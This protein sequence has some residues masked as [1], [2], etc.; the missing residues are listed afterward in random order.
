MRKLSVELG[1]RSYPIFVGSGTLSTLASTLA[2]YINQ[3]VFIITNDVVAPLYLDKVRNQLADHQIAVFQMADGEQAKTLDTWAAA[4]DALLE[5]GFSRDCTVLALGGGVVG[6]LAGFV[7]ASFQ[8][9]V[10]FI[11]IPTTLLSQV[12]SSVGGK[13]AVNHPR[14]KNLVGAFHQPK[15]VLID[16]E[17]LSTLPQRELS[18]GL[19]EVIK[20]G[21]MADAEFFNWLENNISALMA[22]DSQALIHAITRSCECKAEVV[23]LDELE[24]GQRALLNLGHTFAHAIEKAQGFGH[25]LHGEAVAAGIAIASDIAT[26]TVRLSDNDYQ[27]II[28]LLHAANLPVNAPQNMSWT[29]WHE[30]MLRDK[31]VK[32]GKVR[33]IIP[34]AI[35]QAE[36]TDELTEDVLQQAIGRQRRIQHAN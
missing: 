17:C 10:D 12:D 33:F 32:Q 1:K 22:H 18:A 11:Q 13:T 36:I 26:H 7:A 29:Q 23:G 19:A 35:G 21:V 27:R 6:D 3:Q 24:Q 31:K 9:G 8:R 30:L 20:Y 5:S 16:I 2:P 4:L 15:A 34:T 28:A 14:G 25:W